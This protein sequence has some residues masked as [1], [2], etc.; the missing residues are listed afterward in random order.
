V[1]NLPTLLTD[2]NEAKIESLIDKN[3]EKIDSISTYE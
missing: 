2:K 3:Q 1:N